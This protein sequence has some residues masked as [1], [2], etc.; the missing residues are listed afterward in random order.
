M[1]NENNMNRELS[2]SGEGEYF[3]LRA[4]FLKLLDHWWWFVI[5]VPLCVMIAFYIC[6][7]STPVYQVETKVMISDTKKG[8]IGVNPM[9]KELGLFQGNM[10]VE[11]EIVEL[12]SKNL[13]QE[14]VRE[15]ELNVD[16]TRERFPRDRKLYKDSPIK[17]LVDIPEHVKDTV[18]YVSFVGEGVKV[19]NEDREVIFEGGFSEVISFGMYNVSIEKLDSLAREGDEIRVDLLSCKTVTNRV[20]KQLAVSIL[21]KTRVPF[22]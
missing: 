14:V 18:L 8:E 16:Y 10:A 12:K 1:N 6:I 11:N 4:F 7:S 21:E 15:L 3:D 17:V 9:M 22:G 20:Y 19:C 13:V 2:P 5:S